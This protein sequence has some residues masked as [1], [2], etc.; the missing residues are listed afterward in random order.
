[1]DGFT[2]MSIHP[3]L[4]SSPFDGIGTDTP[5]GLLAEIGLLRNGTTSGRAVVA[6]IVELEDGTK[7]V[8]QTTWR[9]F[10]NAHRALAASPIASEEV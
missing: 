8:A 10:T 9:L 1:M 5:S 6:L 4:D 3:N 2:P 7:V